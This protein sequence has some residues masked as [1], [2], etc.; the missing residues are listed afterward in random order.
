MMQIMRGDAYNVAL[1]LK[2]DDNTAITPAD[3]SDVEIVLGN[4]VKR[5]SS[6]DIVYDDGEWLFPITQTD[7]FY[8]LPPVS[9]LQ[10]RVKTGNDVVGVRVGT[11][12]VLP[13]KG[14]IL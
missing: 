13:A 12:F 11:V 4:L 8:D 10:V 3:V 7:T 6:G 1:T 14:E 2:Y 5:Y 9:A